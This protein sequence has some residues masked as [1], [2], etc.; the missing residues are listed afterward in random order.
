MRILSVIIANPLRKVNGAT[1]AGRALSAATAKLVDLDLAVM[2]DATETFDSNGLRTYHRRSTTPLDVFGQAIPRFVK[3]PLYRSDIPDLVRDGSYD[4]VHFHNLI[5]GFAAADVA[6]T[7]S[8]SG[9]PYVISAHGFHELADFAR[10]NGYGRVKVLLA[11]IGVVRPALKVIREASGIFCLTD[12]D[13]QLLDTR[14]TTQAR[15]VRV[16]T[17]GVSDF[18]LEQASSDELAMARRRFGL[19]EGV[20]RLFFMGSLTAFKGADI[21]L[22]SL[23]DL[24]FPHQAIVGGRFWDDDHKRDLI[25]ASEL[26][27]AA[28]AQVVFTGQ[29]EREDLRALYQ[30]ADVFVYPTKG[31]SLPLVVLEAMASRLPVVSTIVGGIPHAV[32]AETGVLVPPGDS[33]AVARVLCELSSDEQR[34]R[35][36][37]AAGRDRVERIFTWSHAAEQAVEGY[38]EV[39]GG[40]THESKTGAS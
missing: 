32:T 10:I 12:R 24:D 28:A 36:L 13:R 23:R 40:P 27:A 8:R 20:L 34:R 37:G 18:Y 19:R 38:R 1:N 7:C 29:L 16:V 6:A 22:R 2:W 11:N 39:L 30:L 31:D 4:I 9:V 21:F 15:V 33:E 14:L 25:A 17:N 35:T 3:I 26:D 5:P